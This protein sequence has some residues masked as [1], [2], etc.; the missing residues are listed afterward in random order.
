MKN[1]IVLTLLLGSITTAIG[2]QNAPTP[3]EA[4]LVISKDNHTV[5]IVDPSTLKVVA[6]LPSGGDPHELVCDDQGKVAYVSNYGLGFGGYNTL[7]VLDLV[8][9]K[10][11]PTIDLGA[12]RFP[13]GLSFA[14]GKVYFTAENNKAIGRYDPVKRKVDWVM[15]TGQTNTHQ[16]KVTPDGTRIFTS[17]VL[18][19]S[20]SVMEIVPLVYAPQEHSALSGTARW[21]PGPSDWRVTSVV[22]G[23]PAEEYEGFDVSPDWKELW[24]ASPHGNVAIIDTAAKKVLQVLDAKVMGANRVQF[25][26]DGKYVLMTARADAMGNIVVFDA[27]TRKQVKRIAAGTGVGGIVMQPDGSRAYASCGRDG[28]VAVIDLKTL[29]LVGKI[30]A[31]PNPDGL[32]WMVRQ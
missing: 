30:D 9:Q 13:H 24:V 22:V 8:G 6:K 16:I 4:L 28:H 29:S 31:G 14:A 1:R 17:N 32:A 23:D 10:Q 18:S 20:V 11:L 3:R 5:A 12:L 2:G 27:A 15:G 7:T 26:P 21:S 19:G 25:T